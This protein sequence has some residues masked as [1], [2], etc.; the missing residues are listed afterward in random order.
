MLHINIVSKAF[1]ICSYVLTM[2]WNGVKLCSQDSM[3]LKI[4]NGTK[5]KTQ[6]KIIHKRHL[7]TMSP[8]VFSCLCTGVKVLNVDLTFDHSSSLSLEG[9]DWISVFPHLIAESHKWNEFF[10]GCFTLQKASSSF[11]VKQWLTCLTLSLL[12]GW[13]FL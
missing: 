7:I 2:C 10:S 4:S 5:Y 13:L 12:G 6:A 9:T 3:I 8:V 1:W 11:R